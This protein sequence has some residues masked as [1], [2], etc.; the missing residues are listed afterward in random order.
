M[1]YKPYTIEDVK[2]SSSRNLFTVISTFAGG[3][4]SSI[5][6]RLS[7]GNVLL[8]NEFVEEA[9]TTYQKNFPETK[10]ICADI[11]SLSGDDF[12][13]A[14]NLKVGEL[15]IFDGS[16]PCS[17]FSLA[18]KR[19]K[20]W[21]KTKNYSDGKT[22]ENI[23]D[24]FL[25]FIRIANDIKPKIIVAENVYGMTVGESKFKLFEFLR[26]FNAIDNNNYYVTHH[27]LAASDY[28]VAQTRKR[29]FFV[30]IRKDVAH[31][32]DI[33]EFSLNAITQ[34]KRHDHVV[35]VG[36]AINDLVNDE[37][38][39]KMLLD[40]AKNAESQS[41]WLKLLELNPTKCISPSDKRFIDINPKLSYFNLI[42]C[43]EHLPSP[44]LTQRGQQ[45]SVSGVFHFSQDRKFTI[46]EL[47]R[48]M[49]L[50]DD[51]ELT[52]TFNQ[53]AERICRMVAPLQM[54]A[55]IDTIYKNILKPY[56]ELSQ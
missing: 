46:K 7:G 34:P 20:G 25:E 19:E 49:S 56:K 29:I 26:E 44:T 18:G 51:Y 43:C 24:L 42:R 40:Y 52:G 53:Q 4:G 33:D 45:V 48:L 54:K 9:V 32:L 39:V 5:G 2:Q 13:N 37:D 35:T 8:M 30:A 12:L 27:V 50:P 55:L 36:E 28:G 23:E 11:K 41:K 21:N 6:Y 15:D 10:A 14:T 22:V 1:G 38:E 16:P 17:A 3:G 31:A 47:K